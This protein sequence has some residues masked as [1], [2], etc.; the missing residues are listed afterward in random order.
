MNDDEKPEAIEGEI[1]E[2]RTWGKSPIEYI[3]QRHMRDGAI[4]RDVTPKKEA[5]RGV[6]GH[7]YTPTSVDEIM[8]VVEEPAIAE[9]L[10]G[11]QRTRDNG[12]GTFT[13]TFIP[14]RR[15][16]PWHARRNNPPIGFV[17]HNLGGP[18]IQVPHR[19]SVLAGQYDEDKDRKG[20]LASLAAMTS[21]ERAK[22][23]E[24]LSRTIGSA[25]NT[26]MQGVLSQLI[27]QAQQAKHDP[28]IR[29]VTPERKEIDTEHGPRLLTSGERA[30]D[31][32]RE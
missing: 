10:K 27:A 1:V 12:D 28:N 29:D 16:F 25:Y 17:S 20:L 5:T 32:A 4:A 23:S 19:I 18:V 8:R 11:T 14:Q 15:E 6:G 9:L 7:S 21:E 24:E 26:L 31:N 3:D 13:H 22:F 2:T 30:D